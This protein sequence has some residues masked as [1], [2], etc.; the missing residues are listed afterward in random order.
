MDNANSE[1]L[2]YIRGANFSQ[3]IPTIIDYE[4]DTYDDLAHYIG[5][6]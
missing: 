2:L 1:N 4:P 3:N 5:E 6:L